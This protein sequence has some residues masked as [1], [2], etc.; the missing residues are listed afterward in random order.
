VLASK[1]KTSLGQWAIETAEI[2]GSNYPVDSAELGVNSIVSLQIHR[3]ALRA[4]TSAFTTFCIEVAA[5]AQLFDVETRTYLYDRVFVYSKNAL[6]RSYETLI[7]QREVSVSS[8]SEPK[9]EDFCGEGGDKTFHEELS[10]ALDPIVNRIV[11]DLGLRL[12]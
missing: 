2:D 4:C 5:R 10:A 6:A 11:Q 3:L 7:S 12:E 9:L 1:L 8:T